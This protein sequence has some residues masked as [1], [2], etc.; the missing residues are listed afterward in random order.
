VCPRLDLEGSFPLEGEHK[1]RPY[2]N[3]WMAGTVLVLT[4]NPKNTVPDDVS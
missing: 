3:D 1:I 4:V 2:E